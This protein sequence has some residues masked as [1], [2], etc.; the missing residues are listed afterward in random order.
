GA[1][2]YAAALPPSHSATVVLSF[3]PDEDVDPGPFFTRQLALYEI[4]ATS[5][6][7]LA[8]AAREAGLPSDALAEAVSAVLPEESLELTINVTTPSEVA[9][10]AAAGSL[11]ETV[12]AAANG[13]PQVTVWTVS[14][15]RVTGDE[16]PLRRA[17]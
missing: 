17:V 5:E 6:Q 10:V 16:T 12:V 13:D 3:A 11:A 14:E 8:Q 2:G 4:A 7:A 15:P 9:S 1:W